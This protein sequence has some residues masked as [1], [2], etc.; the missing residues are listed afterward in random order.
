MVVAVERF[1]FIEFLRLAIADTEGNPRSKITRSVVL[2]EL[3][4]LSDWPKMW[5]GL[6]VTHV[7]RERIAVITPSQRQH[8]DMISR[9]D[10]YYEWKRRIADK[11]GTVEIKQGAIKSGDFYRIRNH[12]AGVIEKI[13]IK[14]GFQPNHCNGTV[15]KVA[16]QLAELVLMSHLFGKGMCAH[17]SGIGKHEV[18]ESGE[19]AGITKC[20]RCNGTGKIPY[21]INEK[22]KLMGLSAMHKSNYSRRYAFYERVGESMIIQWNQTIGD[23]L[24]RSFDNEQKVT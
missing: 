5:A 16:K 10:F 17:C 23:H 9:Y 7:E 1:D 24:R 11:P 14:N 19:S 20:T 22:L 21:T 2:G 18:Y 15:I 13:M 12:I 8:I 6:L 4:L 3:G